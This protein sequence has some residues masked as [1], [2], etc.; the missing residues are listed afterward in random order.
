VASRKSRV[1]E[2]QL[3]NDMFVTLEYSDSFKEFVESIA[4]DARLELLNAI[5]KYYGD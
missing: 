4:E 5:K 3:L 1:N 2:E